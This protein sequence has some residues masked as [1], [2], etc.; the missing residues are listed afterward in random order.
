[1]LR[2]T[3]EVDDSQD[4]IPRL[5]K[6]LGFD[7]MLVPRLEPLREAGHDAINPVERTLRRRPFDFRIKHPERGFPVL[8]VQSGEQPPDHVEVL[9]PHR[10]YLTPVRCSD[11]I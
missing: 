8:A 4:L 10:P 7:V 11:T 3:G 6:F 1:A 5:Q 9:M 2:A